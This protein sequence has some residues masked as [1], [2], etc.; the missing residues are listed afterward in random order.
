MGV[1]IVVSTRVSFVWYKHMLSKVLVDGNVV[2]R[3]RS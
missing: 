3:Q 2:F 1:G